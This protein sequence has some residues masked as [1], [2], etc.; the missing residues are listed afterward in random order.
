MALGGA[1]TWAR[2]AGYSAPRGI[3]GGLVALAPWQYVVIQHLARRVTAP[4]ADGLLGRVPSADELE[5]AEFVDRYLAA[6]RSSLRRDFLHMV[7]F[8]EHVAPFLVGRASRFTELREADQDRVLEALEASSIDSIRA[9]F[10]AIK[11]MVM[12]G[13]YR[14]ARTFS[15][16]GYRGPLVE[17]RVERGP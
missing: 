10:Q 16:I 3:P 2:T 1:L 14:D 9:G 5:V 12:M 7:G 8:V 6:M 4:D 13:Y 17:R 11:S 15:L